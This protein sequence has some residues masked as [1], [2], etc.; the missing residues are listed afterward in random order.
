[1]GRKV[2]G[3]S[4]CTVPRLT[5]MFSQS[6]PWYYACREL[7][8]KW[9]PCVFMRDTTAWGTL[10]FSSCPRVSLS[11]SL[12]SR[13][14]AACAPRHGGHPAATTFLSLFDRHVTS[15]CQGPTVCVRTPGA[16]L[17]FSCMKRLKGFSISGRPRAGACPNAAFIPRKAAFASSVQTGSSQSDLP[18]RL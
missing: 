14:V 3:F 16:T 6:S 12:M 9:C 5:R 8:R 17:S 11:T 1:M 7:E 13:T 15:H 18:K 10:T 4:V 2:A